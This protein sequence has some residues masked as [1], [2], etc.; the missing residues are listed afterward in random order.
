[1]ESRQRAGS[2]CGSGA[3]REGEPCAFDKSLLLSMIK[4]M[5]EKS[6]TKQYARMFWLSLLDLRPKILLILFVEVSFVTLIVAW[7]LQ[8][9]MLADCQR[10]TYTKS[11]LVTFKP[12]STDAKKELYSHC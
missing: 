12:A 8:Q 9:D 3:Y 11:L 10:R 5:P 1:M 7:S 4:L 6:G 2:A